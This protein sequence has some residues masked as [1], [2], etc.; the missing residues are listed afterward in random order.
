VK[1]LVVDVR[2]S[3]G[4][5]FTGQLRLEDAR[6]ALVGFSGGSPACTISQYL[7]RRSRYHVE[8][9]R[10]PTREGLWVPAT[11]EVLEEIGGTGAK[12]ALGA[13]PSRG[14]QHPRVVDRW[15]Y[16]RAGQPA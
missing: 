12:R 14:G 9:W 16:H 15:R 4:E 1:L 6:L 11:S 3:N 7:H 2:P 10:T 13:A 8:A 5:G